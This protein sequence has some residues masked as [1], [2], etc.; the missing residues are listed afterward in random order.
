MEICEKVKV[1]LSHKKCKKCY[2][3]YNV[4]TFIIV[5]T[6]RKKFGFSEEPEESILVVGEKLYR[7]GKIL[8]VGYLSKAFA[9]EPQTKVIFS[10]SHCSNVVVLDLSK[11]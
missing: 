7:G 10:C 4:N 11:F 5:K 1:Q 8:E 9:E 6:K 3:Q 2:K